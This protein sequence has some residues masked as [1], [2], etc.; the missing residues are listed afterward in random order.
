MKKNTRQVFLIILAII[1]VTMICTILACCDNDSNQPQGNGSVQTVNP[2]EDGIEKVEY[3]VSV[4][5]PDG[6]AVVGAEVLLYTFDDE[7]EAYAGATTG[8]D[9]VANINAGKGLEYFI[10]LKNIPDGYTY[11]DEVVINS[12]E[13]EKEIFLANANASDFYN[14]T[15]VTVGGMPMENV[16]VT[17]KDGKNI[18]GK[19]NTDEN[20]AVTIRVS[21][22]KEY[23][24]ELSE[25]PV[26]YSLV[27]EN[28]TTSATEVNQE[29][30]VQSSVIKEDI[31]KNY[32]YEMDDIMYDFTLT[33]SDGSKFI[34]S[35]AL[36]KYDLVVINFWAS[37]CIPCKSEF[38]GMQRAYERYQDNMA[39]IAISMDDSL[40]EVA[41]Y[42]STY[43]I[44][45]TF[46]MSADTNLYSNFTIYHGGAVPHTVF[47]DRYGKIC[48]FITGGT[49][50]ALFR[51]EFARYTDPDYVQVAYDPDNDETPSDEPEAPDVEM[52]S[53]ES[54]NSAINKDGFVGEYVAENDGIVWPWI[55]SDNN[56]LIPGNIKHNNTTASINYTFKLKEGEFLA[57]DY[58]TNTEDV[59]N[60]DI[61]TAYIDGSAVQVLDRITNG[62]WNTVY[63]YTP[64]SSEI[65]D[66]DAEREHTLTL[67]Y[68]KDN[69]DG[70]LTG[71]EVVAIKDMR[72]VKSS[73]FDD[74]TDVNILRG[75]AW[76]YD[77][78]IKQWTS[79][80]T[81][82]Y[83]EEDGYYHVGSKDGPYLLAN[84]CGATRYSNMSVSEY[85]SNG[86]FKMA[87]L[88]SLATLITSGLDNPPANSYIEWK[89]G[90]AWFA[91][92]SSIENFTLVDEVLKNTLDQMCKRFAETTYQGNKLGSYYTENSWLELCS[93]Y[94]NYNGNP[95]ENP[96]IGIS[97]KEA[98]VAYDGEY[99]NHVVVD[100]VLVPRGMVYRYD[101]IEGGAYKI[102]SKMADELVGK[103]GAY[104]CVSGN[105]VDA[106][107]DAIGDF[108]VFVTFEA[109][110]SYY[111]YVAFDLP[112]TLGEMDFYIERIATSYDRFTY[113][114]NG[115]Y[116]WVV[117]KDGNPI[118]DES[119]NIVYVLSTEV[120]VV[121]DS[122][123]N[124]YRQVLPDGS[125]DMGEKGQIYISLSEGNTFFEY[126]LEQLAIGKAGSITIQFEELE[127]INF[128]DFTNE[129]GIDYTDIVLEYVERAKAQEGE[130]NG[131]IIA[132]KQL[133][134]IIEMAMNR[135]GHDSGNAWL[136][137]AFYYQHLGEYN[138]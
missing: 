78:E 90:Y 1:L 39:I 41:S 16:A 98:I 94:D 125:S 64:L 113:V 65:D 81:P 10:V 13:R 50:E 79:Y 116:T 100:K 42:K 76:A 106:G 63:L 135:V 85:V 133:V 9:G 121:Y 55:L 31:P 38:E 26:G 120:D 99:A 97:D 70:F 101:C 62:A 69:S 84:I 75:G 127:G 19:K 51:Q 83:N 126:T 88:Q 114:S 15:V 117:D 56:E 89:K 115:L 138:G 17:L 14:I 6:S 35:E 5:L 58:C 43:H 67:V 110:K 29:I 49:S 137:F 66:Q 80:I 128:F 33:T 71:E 119:G 72:A 96:L 122:E 73:E 40:S 112:D 25:L 22:K 21:E 34:L 20:G 57:F 124:T 28:L 8:N 37:W 77:S 3:K 68:A 30:K 136:G 54:I 32:R 132:D 61:L 74:K 7:M 95:I 92:Y 48:N 27:G 91:T 108:E 118:Y 59:A 129:G 131:Y 111:I 103:H 87:S 18:V 130:L 93:Y 46:D 109:G 2:P 86:Y 123:T 104:I 23:T 36:E 11:E 44:A 24:I 107:D 105:G 53:S 4:K 134:D 47:V 45:L 52:P 102:Y 82:V 12:D 60:A